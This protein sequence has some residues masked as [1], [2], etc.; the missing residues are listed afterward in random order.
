MTLWPTGGHDA[1]TQASDPEY[2]EEGMNIYEW[3]LQYKR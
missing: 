3:M 2:R 1:W